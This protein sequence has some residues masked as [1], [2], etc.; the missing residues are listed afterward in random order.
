M[1]GTNAH[2]KKCESLPGTE[3]GVETAEGTA[4]Q[5]ILSQRMQRNGFPI[6]GIAVKVRTGATI[7][8]AQ[9]WVVATDSVTFSPFALRLW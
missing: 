3:K 9:A 6:L 8:S 7:I 5:W 1:Y 4:I 2:I